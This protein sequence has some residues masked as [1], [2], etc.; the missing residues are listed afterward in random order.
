MKKSYL[1]LLISLLSLLAKSQVV[2]I[3]DAA[4]KDKLLSATVTNE[5]AK[6]INGNSIVIDT[7][8][9]GEIEVAEALTVYKLFNITTSGPPPFKT[10]APS[11]Q[12]LSGIADLTGI[13][14]F[15]NL[16]YLQISSNFLT[17]LDLS[18]N[19]NLV[20][21]SCSYNHLNSINLNGLTQLDTLS[22]NDNN[23]TSLST[24]GLTS[25]RILNCANNDL[26]SLTVNNSL[27]LKYLN[28]SLNS[29]FNVQVSALSNLETYFCASNAISTLSIGNLVNLKYFDCYYNSVSSLDL[30]TFPN[31]ISLKCGYN[32]LTGL[33]LSA[34]P[35]LEFL[36]CPNNNLTTLSFVNNTIIKNIN[37]S[38]NQIST[39]TIAVH[40]LLTY[41]S[42]SG[43][44]FTQLDLSSTGVQF[45]YCGSNPNLTFINIKNGSVGLDGIQE[46]M[47]PWFSY[48]YDLA[49]LPSLQY[50]CHD[51][52]EIGPIEVAH[53]NLQNVSR[54]T[55][56]SF[57]PG[58]TYTTI[59]GLVS[60]DC[61]GSNAAIYNQKLEVTSG[62]QGG[63]TFS[64]ATGNYT[65]YTGIGTV[66]VAPQLE[67]PSY[68]TVTPA[69][70][71]YTLTAT[72]T[73]QTADFCLAPNG[74]HPDLEVSM[75]PVTTARPGFDA[76]Y[77]LDY[78][79]KGNQVQ[80]GSVVLS[81]DHLV[82]DFVS[83]S[84]AINLQ[85]TDQLQWDISGL[86]PF[87]SGSILLTLHIHAP[88]DLPAVTLG[89]ILHY[90]VA[91]NSTVSDETP[92]DNQQSFDQTVVGSF[93]PNDKTVVEGATISLD[94]IGDYLHY[95]VHFQ[96][97]GSDYAANIVIKDLL[98]SHLEPGTLEM[99]SSSHPFRSTLTTVNKLEVFYE[100]INLPASSVDE[101]ASHGY[102]AFKIKPKN[103]VVI[104]DVIPNTAGIYFDYNLP[105]V[106]NTVTTTVT[107]LGTPTHAMAAVVTLYPNP[108]EG[109]LHIEV[110][111]STAIQGITICNALGQ[112]VLTAKETSIL[113][114]TSLTRG[115]YV[116]TV[117][118]DKGKVTQKLLKL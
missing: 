115:T 50:I 75:I 56:C 41:F 32:Q 63:V 107:A 90:T 69:N 88:T 66:T 64:N 48:Y 100:G 67:N 10:S 13:E 25:L 2:T 31:L 68:F 78:K 105:I 29:L 28:C 1:L 62:T 71:T 14:A 12:T 52:G 4:F 80:N 111:D 60:F 97:T 74:V 94:K 47:L 98:D 21:L 65:F 103:T 3:P 91:L 84:P 7:N 86:Q 40:P 101:A 93:D 73:T 24:D 15:T 23:L 11:Q 37:I 54:G 72:G 35:L 34:V 110:V 79:N 8:A 118:T 81:F 45:L 22:I 102:I 9:N 96:N 5:Y 113:D 33:D 55:Y 108:V 26:S 38:N 16:T 116:V 104:N 57:E 17:N 76:V 18:S 19:T 83:A 58:G 27:Q 99:E 109:Q 112:T 6:D 87:Q 53:D 20:Y 42:G 89:T 61:G 30:S 85:N 95:I 49:N 51:Q 106:T 114:V 46:P 92:N 36:S 59:N 44:L 117:I 43:N 77:R 39:L 70:Y 82:S